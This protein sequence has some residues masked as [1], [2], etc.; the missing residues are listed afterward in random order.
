M[1]IVI[2][3]WALNSY[4]ELRQ[5]R[6]FSDQEYRETIRPDVLLLQ[7]YPDDP[8]FQNPKFWSAVTDQ[9]KNRIRG[10]FK[11]KW[12]QIGPGRVQLRL[13]VGIFTEAILCEAYVKG[14][15]KEE[16]RKIARFKMYLE[17]IARG[18]YTERGRLK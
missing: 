1:E 6:M 9:S 4:L 3:E 13:P 15:E 16:R 10:G 2:T 8:K 18:Q 12:H 17:L 11:M 5:K 14:N 7:R